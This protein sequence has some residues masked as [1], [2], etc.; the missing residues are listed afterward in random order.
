M[1]TAAIELINSENI[2][3]DGG[4]QA[5]E[6]I[7]YP[8]VDEYAD[9]MEAGIEFPPLVV[10]FDG[11]D[12]WLADGFHRLYAYRQQGTQPIA[13]EVRSG[14]QDDAVLYAVGTNSEHGLRR[15]NADKRKAVMMVLGRW[16]KWSDRKIAEACGVSNHL[17]ADARKQLGESPSC[18]NRRTGAD[19]KTRRIPQPAVVDDEPSDGEPDDDEQDA[20]AE[21]EPTPKKKKPAKPLSPLE[22]VADDLA[23]QVGALVTTQFCMACSVAGKPCSTRVVRRKRRQLDER[24]LSAIRQVKLLVPER[25]EAAV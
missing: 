19:G 5:R 20:P 16:S 21:P 13:C 9:A 12:Y 23:N 24:G 6:N 1:A 18:D 8:I 2:R 7:N 15:T 11:S 25:Q 10:F 22:I 4:T 17:V 14:S 3:T